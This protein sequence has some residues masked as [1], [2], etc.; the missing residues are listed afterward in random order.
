MKNVIKYLEV[1]DEIAVESFNKWGYYYPPKTWDEFHAWEKKSFE[2]YLKDKPLD[3]K[4]I[5]VY[6][7]I[8]DYN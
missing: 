8:K 4:N 3:L 2:K 7:S 6:N 5:G 1:Y